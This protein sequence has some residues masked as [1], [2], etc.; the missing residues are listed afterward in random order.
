ML[1]RIIICVVSA[2]FMAP[3]FAAVTSPVF[4]TVIVPKRYLRCVSKTFQGQT[5]VYTLAGKVV[6]R[7]RGWSYD[8]FNVKV[9]LK[10]DVTGDET[11]PATVTGDV[12]DIMTCGLRELYFT[13]VITG[14]PAGTYRAHVVIDAQQSD[15]MKKVDSLVSLMTPTEKIVF[16]NG[17]DGCTRLGIPAVGAR[18]GP[19]GTWNGDLYPTGVATACTFDTA[20]V[21]T[22]AT[23]KGEDWRA[24]SITVGLGPMLNLIRDARWGRAFE[25]YSEDP[26]LSG[27]LLAADYRGVWKRSVIAVAKHVACYNAENGRSQYPVKISERALRELYLPAFKTGIDEGGVIGIMTS[28][29]DING[30]PC[31]ENKHLLTDVIKNEWGFRGI[32]MSDWNSVYNGSAAAGNAGLDVEMPQGRFSTTSVAAGV[33]DE[34]VRRVVWTRCKAGMLVPG[35]TAKAY[36]DRMRS[37]AHIAMTRT[38]GRETI[39]LAKNTGGILPLDR[40][41][42]LKLAVVGSFADVMRPGSGGSSGFPVPYEI[43]PRQ[44]IVELCGPNVTVGTDYNNC[45]YAI[46]VVGINDGGETIDRGN[47]DL[48]NGQN[49]FVAQVLK[50]KPDKTIVVF[51]GGSWAIAGAWSTAPAVVIALYPGQEQAHALADVLFGDYNPAGRLSISFPVDASQVPPWNAT[52]EPAWEGRGYFYYDNK[53]LTPLFAFGH[54]LSYT[55]FDYSNL[56]ISPQGVFMPDRVTVSVDVANTGARAG[57]EVIQLYVKPPQTTVQRRIKDLRGFKRIALTP[58]EKKT[59]TFHLSERDLAY[60]SETDSL[61]TTEPGVYT[62]QIGASSRDIRQQGS[63]TLY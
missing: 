36:V 49:D 15:T 51:T 61:F 48:P 46:V 62:V 17:T 4:D 11:A 50:V 60:F 26:F 52:Y 53:N 12:G 10:S 58:G 55:T 6:Y 35:Y 30:S 41:K 24:N 44:G 19:Y 27:K 37:P 32:I 40:T 9:T 63:F 23:C 54:G 47:F 28:M 45:D 42:P 31:S 13:T 43:T 14:E 20:V 25:T 3:L 1:K 8:R 5:P 18:D 34:M 59:V 39:V 2:C 22:M 7:F 57:D 21:E 38:I 56:S 33:L 16:V 29:N